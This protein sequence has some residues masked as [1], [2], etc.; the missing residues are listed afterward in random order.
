MYKENKFFPNP[1][2]KWYVQVGGLKICWNLNYCAN[3]SLFAQQMKMMWAKRHTIREESFD[4]IGWEATKMTIETIT[5]A[6]VNVD[7][8]TFIRGMQG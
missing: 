7:C 2:E 3:D 8:Q 5:L 4:I 6:K 1:S